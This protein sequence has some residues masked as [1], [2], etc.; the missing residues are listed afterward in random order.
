MQTNIVDLRL[1]DTKCPRFT[2]NKITLD[3]IGGDDRGKIVVANHRN[4]DHTRKENHRTTSYPPKCLPC[5]YVGCITY[6]L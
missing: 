6:T 1:Y 3:V 5:P 4:I 2:R